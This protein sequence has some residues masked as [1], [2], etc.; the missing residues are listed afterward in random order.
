[1]RNLDPYEL[2]A[3]RDAS[4]KAG[5]Y[6]DELDAGRGKSDLADLTEEEW[7]KFWDVGLKEFGASIRRQVS[8][9]S[10]PW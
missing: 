9:G 3:R 10:A 6:L 5:A 1:M 7:L 4:E 8:E 2:I